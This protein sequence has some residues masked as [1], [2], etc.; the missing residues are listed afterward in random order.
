[1]IIMQ[2]NI[3]G[4]KVTDKQYKRRWYEKHKEYVLN[5]QKEYYQKHKKRLQEKANNRYRIKCGLKPLE[6]NNEKI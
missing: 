3:L 1:M 5:Y 4:D 6:D 2:E